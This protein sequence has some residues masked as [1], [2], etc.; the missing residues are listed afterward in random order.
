MGRFRTQIH[1]HKLKHT[2][3]PHNLNKRGVRKDT[4]RMFQHGY[5]GRGR[6]RKVEINKT[7]A[8][9]TAP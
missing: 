1:V 5:L 3:K 7:Q 8:E 9:M 2:H 4:P 6:A